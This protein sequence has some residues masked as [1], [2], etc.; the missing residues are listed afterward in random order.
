VLRIR[1]RPFYLLTKNLCKP[2]YCPLAFKFWDFFFI[3]SR[4]GPGAS[5]ADP[6]PLYPGSGLGKKSRSG[7]VINIPDHIPESLETI[8]GF[9]ILKFYDVDPGS[10]IF[11]T[12]DSGSWMEKN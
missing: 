7:S 9:K 5:L 3:S 1:D 2:E 11:L 8:F 10:E 6:K 4:G 12:L